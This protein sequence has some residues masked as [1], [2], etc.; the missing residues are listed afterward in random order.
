MRQGNAGRQVM[1]LAWFISYAIGMALVCLIGTP[2]M[3]ILLH[4]LIGAAQ[5]VSIPRET[6]P[7]M[8]IH[9]AVITL[10][11]LIGTG[12]I[13]IMGW[14]WSQWTVASEGQ[15]SCTPTQNLIMAAVGLG[16]F[17]FTWLR[18]AVADKLKKPSPPLC[19]SI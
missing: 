18:Y 19:I 2:I 7:K 9:P 1:R 11:C 13:Y 15:L 10:T 8:T 14:F 3:G 16:A 6:N 5:T 12:V 4:M 17:W